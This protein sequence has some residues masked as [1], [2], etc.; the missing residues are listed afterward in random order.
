MPLNPSKDD[1]IWV[2][3]DRV[4]GNCNKPMPKQVKIAFSDL[5]MAM[6]ASKAARQANPNIG[7]S[8]SR[9]KTKSRTKSAEKEAR[10]KFISRIQEKIVP[11]LV[12]H[13]ITV[14]DDCIWINGSPLDKLATARK[15]YN[16][17]FITGHMQI[18]KMIFKFNFIALPP[19]ASG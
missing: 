6:D 2:N 18:N 9:S 12:I 15:N 8:K 7:N 16:S 5:C 17:Q 19:T 14:V 10:T 13:A 1:S 4:L 11:G 3:G